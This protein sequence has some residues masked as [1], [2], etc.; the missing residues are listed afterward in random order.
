MAE[1]SVALL[2]QGQ[3][4]S[5]FLRHG[6]GC[7]SLPSLWDRCAHVEPGMCTGVHMQTLRGHVGHTTYLETLLGNVHTHGNTGPLL[8]HRCP[9][10][11]ILDSH[12]AYLAY[13]FSP[14]LKSF[15]L[16][17]KSELAFGFDVK[18]KTLRPASFIDTASLL[19]AFGNFPLWAWLGVYRVGEYLA[20]GDAEAPPG[21]YTSQLRLRSPI[22]PSQLNYQEQAWSC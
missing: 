1:D 2:F 22:P 21:G 13:R 10:S 18:K 6:G 7:C 14:T 17:S 19:P 16:F 4:T 15:P 3:G 20:Q 9:C 8:T 5:H 11:D 12:L